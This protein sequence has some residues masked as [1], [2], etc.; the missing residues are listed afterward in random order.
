MR[1]FTELKL[2]TCDGLVKKEKLW[3]EDGQMLVFPKHCLL[4]VFAFCSILLNLCNKDLSLIK[5][6]DKVEYLTR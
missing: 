2:M 6:A 5:K 3:I 1:K 4:H